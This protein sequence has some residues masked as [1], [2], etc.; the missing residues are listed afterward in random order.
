[1]DAN[2]WEKGYQTVS[3]KIGM[4]VRATLHSEELKEIAPKIVPVEAKTIVGKHNNNKR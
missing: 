3:K 4:N 2:P 1:M